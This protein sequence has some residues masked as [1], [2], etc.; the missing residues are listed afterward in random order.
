MGK[1]KGF[2][3]KIVLLSVLTILI[4]GALYIYSLYQIK[5]VDVNVNSLQ[6]ISLKGFTLGGDIEVYNE[7]FVSV[8]IDHIVYDVILEGS[9]NKLTEG[10]V[11]GGVIPAKK[12]TNFHFSNKINWVPSAEL[13]SNLIIPGKTYANI[14]G[15]IY[16][17]DLF[18]TDVKV[19]FQKRVD[20]EYYIRQFVKKKAEQTVDNVTEAIINTVD[21]VGEGIKTITGKVIDGLGVLFG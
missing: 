5:V 19:P 14:D 10:Y 8:S 6:D 1:K 17:K 18:F 21:K 3:K 15:E 12:A 7:G 11:R 9:G 4:Y 20:L 13:A 16:V 2:F